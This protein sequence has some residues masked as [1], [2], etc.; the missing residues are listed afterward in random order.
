MFL[1]K[2]KTW[3]PQYFSQSSFQQPVKSSDLIFTKLHHIVLQVKSIFLT[4]FFK[5]LKRFIVAQVF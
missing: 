4:Y 5:I 1:F 2:L 3:Q